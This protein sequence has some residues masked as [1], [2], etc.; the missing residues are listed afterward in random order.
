MLSWAETP[1]LELDLDRPVATRYAD[2]PEWAVQ[3]GLALLDAVMKLIP[4]AARFLADAVNLRTHGRFREEATAIARRVGA[5][6]RSVMLANVSYDLALTTFGCSTAALPTADGPVIARNMDWW[7][8]A[9][10]ARTSVLIRAVR[11]GRLQFAIAGWPG[12]IGLVTGLSGRGFA[13]VLNAVLSPEGTRRTGYPLLLFLRRV[14]EEAADFDAAVHMLTRQTLASPGLITVVGA[15]NHQRVVIERSPG[16]HALRWA[17][18]DQPLFATN[19]YRVLY[20]PR[21][22]PAGEPLYQTACTRYQALAS[23]FAKHAPERTV[24]DAELLYVLT[25]PGIIQGITAQHVILRPREEGVRLLVPRRLL[26]E[27]PEGAAT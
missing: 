14:L 13:L 7:P 10:L 17:E 24:T 16:R 1:T 25:D 5:D 15:Q 12:S 22:E 23:A 11:G 4:P 27:T 3:N 20:P 26:G 21:S 2:V 9:V 6:W 18:P 19:D 8:E